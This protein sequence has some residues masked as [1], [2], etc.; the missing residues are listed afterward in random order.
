ME[1][2]RS[3]SYDSQISELYRLAIL[4]VGIHSRSGNSTMGRY[5]DLEQSEEYLII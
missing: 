2:L 3:I 4:F 5:R 1:A